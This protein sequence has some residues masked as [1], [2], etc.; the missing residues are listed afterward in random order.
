MSIDELKQRLHALGYLTEAAMLKGTAKTV[1]TSLKRFQRF[2]GLEP[3]GKLDTATERLL[4]APLR[5]SLPDFVT[6]DTGCRWPLEKMTAVSY[7]VRLQLPGIT[8][9]VAAATFDQACRQW[10]AVCGIRFRKLATS[11]GANIAAK[12]GAGR[13]L[14]LDGA[15]G[16]LAWSYMPCNATPTMQLAQM[17]DQAERWS[18]HM[19]LAVMCHEIG[20]AIGLPHGKPGQLMA[21]YY[22]A[23]VT[24]PQ[25]GDTLEAVK[26]YGAPKAAMT[27]AAT[28]VVRVARPAVLEIRD[29]DDKLVTTLTFAKD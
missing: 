26:R 24:M 18:Q 13:K 16:T 12:S 8:P 15:G 25:K 29:E 11:R 19:A 5:C 3:A 4:V 22:N 17:Y 14:F 1:A 23:D 6:D 21:P 28:Q 27:Q 20:H 10:E 7:H 9:A 2:N